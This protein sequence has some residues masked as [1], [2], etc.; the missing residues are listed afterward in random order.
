[1]LI[2]QHRMRSEICDLISKPMYKGKLVTAAGRETVEGP[3]PP[4]P[5]DG[6]LTIIDTSA[7]KPFESQNA[8]FSRFNLL[9][10]LLARNLVWHF[11]QKGVIRT[12]RD[13]GICTPYAAQAR[14]IQKLLE[15]D[16]L[17]EF[18]H[19]GTVHRF[20]GDER[21]MVLLEIPESDGGFWALGQF[22]QGVPPT[23]IGARLINVAVSRAQEHMVV[24]ANLTYL[25]ERLPSRAL[26]RSILCDM[27]QHGRIVSGEHLL[28]LRP[29]ASDLAGP[30]RPSRL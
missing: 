9:H 15:G 23:H 21:R 25:D 13:L 4:K 30:G 1:M 3:S 6:A 11:Q 10:A 19:A 5:F 17:D 20:Q 8:F 27:Q 29:I 16:G 7:L 18:V 24:L 12:N 2:E 26:L 22:V 28:E 14:L